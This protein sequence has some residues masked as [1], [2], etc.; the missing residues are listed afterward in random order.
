[1]K[2]SGLVILGVVAAV[3]V[4]DHLSGGWLQQKLATASGYVVGTSEAKLEAPAP[5]SSGAAAD[6]GG[7]PA[8]GGGK[9]GGGRNG[10]NS[11]P[12]PVNTITATA[13]DVAVRRRTIGSVMPQS[14]LSVTSNAQGMLVERVAREGA[15]IKAGDVIARLD[16]RAALAAVARDKA[17]IDRDTATLTGAQNDL[18]RQ[19][20]LATSNVASGQ[21]LQDAQTAVATATATIELDKATLAAD[22]VTLDYMDIR[23][24]ITGRLGAYLVAVGNVIQPG[25]AV[26]QLTQMA[27]VDVGFSMAESDIAALR[28]AWGKGDVGVTVTPTTTTSVSDGAEPGTVPT[29]TGNLSFIDSRIDPLSGT[30]AAK[31]VLP[32]ADLAMWPG[33]SVSVDVVLAQ[34]RLVAV[35]SMAVQPAQEG[36]IVYVVADGKV[37]VRPV[38]IGLVDGDVTG[39]SAG[40]AEGDKVITEGQINLT[41]GMA[42][43]EV[44]TPAPAA[45]ANAV[46]PGPSAAA[47]APKPVAT[48]E[49]AK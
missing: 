47:D 12:K 2:K 37:V 1:M 5:G 9:G 38:T 31:A 26:V 22:Q 30:F 13:K 39:I 24:P 17:M 25:D 41:D 18:A 44:A 6:A 19:Q 43:A 14:A 15:D 42:V 32:N 27:P 46:V 49:A 29:R 8:E 11:G 4:G 40:L 21:A 3:V 23:A 20:K 36:S 28:E 45:D 7:K 10:R 16:N 33:Q 48:V 35:P 34:R